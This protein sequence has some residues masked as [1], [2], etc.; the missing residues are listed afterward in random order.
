MEFIISNILQSEVVTY[1]RIRGLILRYQLI[2]IL[3]RKLFNETAEYWD[4]VS[5]SIFRDEYPRYPTID[6]RNACFLLIN[7]RNLI[8]IFSNEFGYLALCSSVK[9]EY[10]L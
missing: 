9:I 7:I 5:A 2:V 10:W 8:V 4:T 1:G 6:V 3:Q